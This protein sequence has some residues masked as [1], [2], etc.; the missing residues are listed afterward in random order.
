MSDAL[1]ERIM[2]GIEEMEQVHGIKGGLYFYKKGECSCCYGLP[3]EYAFQVTENLAGNWG[4]S[5]HN[6]EPYHKVTFD[7]DKAQATILVRTLRKHLRRTGWR[8]NWKGTVHD[9]I[10]IER[11]ITI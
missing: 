8:V 4:V 7:L 3:S 2:T 1:K 9:A 10:M 5:L 6:G 11:P